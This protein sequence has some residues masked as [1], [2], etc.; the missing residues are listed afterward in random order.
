MDTISRMNFANL[1]FGD[2]NTGTNPCVKYV[3]SD[4]TSSLAVRIVIVSNMLPICAQKDGE[5]WSFN[6]DEDSPLWQLKDGFS[7]DAVVFYV[8]SLN[9]DIDVNEQEE[10]AQRLLDDFNCVP[11]FLTNDLVE[12]FYHGFCKHHL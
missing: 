9:A 3:D 10:I 8:G 5:G 4:G 6:Y 12:K 11:T 1:A 7:P 2:V